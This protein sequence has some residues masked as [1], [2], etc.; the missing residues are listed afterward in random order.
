[1]SVTTPGTDTPGIWDFD[2]P[3]LEWAAKLV[4]LGISAEDRA[5]LLGAYAESYTG[6]SIGADWAAIVG[7]TKVNTRELLGIIDRLAG[8]ARR[9]A[10]R[11]AGLE[12]DLAAA[13][14]MLRAECARAAQ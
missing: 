14:E 4:T 13:N 5:A 6:S 2:L 10:Q 3:A 1:M 9:D 8:Q 11:I 12:R 7:L